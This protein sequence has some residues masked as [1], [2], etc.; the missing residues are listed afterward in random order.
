MRHWTSHWHIVQIKKHLSKNNPET[1]LFC[2]KI[3]FIA[4]WNY[5]LV[6]MY[7]NSSKQALKA[8]VGDQY[9]DSAKL[10]YANLQIDDILYLKLPNL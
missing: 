9:H 4:V 7:K 1:T 6:I 2:T 5:C 10:I 3:F 8:V